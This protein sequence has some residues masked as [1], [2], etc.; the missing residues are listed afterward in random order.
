MGLPLRVAVTLRMLQAD[1]PEAV[2][3]R[4]PEQGD[5]APEVQQGALRALPPEVLDRLCPD[6]TLPDSA[7]VNVLA[8]A[9]ADKAF[10]GAPLNAHPPPVHVAERFL[11]LAFVR[12]C[13]SAETNPPD[14]DDLAD[15]RLEVP[16][17][18]L[19]DTE[20]LFNRLADFRR[21]LDHFAGMLDD[22]A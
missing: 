3:R 22:I 19:G 8:A 4:P 13:R 16:V 1:P 21:N 6:Q 5:I 20:G 7:E 10:S 9:D 15:R 2:L 18:I 11:N 12:D 17:G 14:I